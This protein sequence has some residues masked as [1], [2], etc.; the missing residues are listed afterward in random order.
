MAA[1]RML[2]LIMASLVAAGIYLSGYTTVHWILYLPA[3]GLGFAGITGI[4]P[5]MVLLKK[6]GFA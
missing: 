2:F 5:G 1:Q 3:I 6:I 4:C